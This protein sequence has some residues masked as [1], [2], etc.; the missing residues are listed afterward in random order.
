MKRSLIYL[1]LAGFLFGIRIPA[2]PIDAGHESEKYEDAKA[3]LTDLAVLTEAFVEN[4][5]QVDEPKD[6]AKALDAF[7]ESMKELVPRIN[8]IR[9]KYPELDDEDTHPEELKPL[10]QRVDK[11]FQM[12]MKAYTKVNANIEDPAVEEADAK[13]KEVMSALG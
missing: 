8:E 5:D 4:M 3:V 12:M 7:A 11:D 13:F 10:L 2:F 6:V 1:V 9:K